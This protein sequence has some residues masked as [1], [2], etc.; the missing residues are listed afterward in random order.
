MNTPPAPVV[1]GC[2]TIG[3]WRSALLP[4]FAGAHARLLAPETPSLQGIF[5]FRLPG[6]NSIVQPSLRTSVLERHTPDAHTLV[7]F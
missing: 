3:P 2:S 1:S 4:G 6:G 7:V 5:F